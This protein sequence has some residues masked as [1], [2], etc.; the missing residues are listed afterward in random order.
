MGYTSISCNKTEPCARYGSS[1]FFDY[2]NTF[3]KFFNLCGDICY[4][5]FLFQRK[6]ILYSHLNKFKIQNMITYIELWKAKQA[7]VDLNK[8]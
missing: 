4:T 7:W 6:R 5:A 1:S 3:D 8:E 2:E